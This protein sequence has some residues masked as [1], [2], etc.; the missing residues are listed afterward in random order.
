LYSKG[1]ELIPKKRKDRKIAIA[2]EER[3]SIGG[4]ISGILITTKKRGGRGRSCRSTIKSG[5]K[6]GRKTLRNRREEMR[7]WP[8]PSQ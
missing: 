1:Y 2:T 4:E 5:K 7:R 6:G 3:Y 8:S